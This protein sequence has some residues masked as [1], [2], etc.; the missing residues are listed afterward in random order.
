MPS[1]VS[2]SGA[3]EGNRRRGERTTKEDSVCIVAS[4][5]VWVGLGEAFAD[6]F[7]LWAFKGGKLAGEPC[8][9]VAG[10]GRELF[11]GEAFAK[12]RPHG[13]GLIIHF[14]CESYEDLKRREGKVADRG[15]A[16]APLGAP[17]AGPRLSAIF[18]EAS[19]FCLGVAMYSEVQK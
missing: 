12:L 9:L 17:G 2:F 13:F 7:G 16:L 19:L 10:G 5:G 3:G 6:D 14:T 4:A 18:F 8:P 15:E 1:Q 11:I